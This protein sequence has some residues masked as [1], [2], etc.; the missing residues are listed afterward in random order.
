MFTS[1]K[2]TVSYQNKVTK[3]LDRAPD[4]KSRFWSDFEISIL[5]KYYGKKD[6]RII[7]KALNRSANTVA[8]YA[9]Y[10]GLTLKKKNEDSL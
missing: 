3:L 1:R 10:I 9:S 7:A 8:R 2:Q 5:K 6:I 4:I